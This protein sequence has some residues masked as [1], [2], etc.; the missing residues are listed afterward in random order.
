MK[1]KIYN[2]NSKTKNKPTVQIKWKSK[3]IAIFVRSQARYILELN[4][5]N[6]KNGFSAVRNAGI[7]FQKKINIFM[8]E[9]ESHD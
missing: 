5:L 1:L 9:L 3:K 7:L 4:L 6:T 8:E 2:L